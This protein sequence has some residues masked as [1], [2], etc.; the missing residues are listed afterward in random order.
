MDQRLNERLQSWSNR[1]ESLSKAEESFLQLEASEKTLEASLFLKATGRTVEERKSRAY[2]T[3]SWDDFKKALATA[4]TEYNNQKRLLD[5]AIK[6][7]EAEYL[8]FKIESE[9]IHKGKGGL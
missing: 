7:Y 3:K 6:A 9:M 8:T 2:Y 5:L 4:K 1:I